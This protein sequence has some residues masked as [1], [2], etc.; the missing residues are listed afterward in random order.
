[1]MIYYYILQIKK[2]TNVKEIIKLLSNYVNC[3]QFEQYK[4]N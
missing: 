1:M 3:N 4:K 2:S